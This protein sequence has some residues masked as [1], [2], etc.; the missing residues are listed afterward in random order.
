MLA[1]KFMFSEYGLPK[2]MMSDTGSNFV[3]DK[4]KQF[5]ENLNIEKAAASSYHHQSNEQVEACIKF[6]KCTIKKCIYTKI[7]THIAILQKEQPSL[8]YN[9]NALLL[10]FPT[11][12]YEALHQ[13]IN[14]F[15]ID[16]NND[17]EHCEAVVTRQTRNDKNYDTSRSYDIFSIGPTV[18]VQ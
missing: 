9:C 16:S 6:I 3:S 1:C 11:V 17:D 13:L 18:A 15:P 2:K 10:C 8:S 4:F 5:C 7:D 14:K 12:Q